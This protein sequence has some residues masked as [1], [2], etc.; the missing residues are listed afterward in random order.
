MDVKTKRPLFLIIDGSSLLT[1]AYFATLPLEIKICKTEAEREPLYRKLMHA[2]DGTFT[3][4][5]YGFC[6]TFTQMLRD[7]QPNMVAVVF[8]RTRD[9]F[10]R[11]MYPE[12]KAQ[13]KETARPLKEQ[14]I[15]I[16]DILSACGIVALASEEY[17]AD[18][19]AGTLTERYKNHC[20]I[21]LYTKDRDYLQLV[22]DACDVR[23]LM[24]TDAEKA[25]GFRE[26]YGGIYGADGIG[27]PQFWKTTVEYTENSVFG[28]FGIWP[29]NVIDLKAIEGDVSDNI[30]G[31]KG[32]SSAAV[33][34]INEYG[35]L[36]EIYKAIDGCD[37]VK[38]EKEL[39]AFWKDNLGIKRSPINAFVKYCGDAVLSKNLATIRTD[40][41]IPAETVQFFVK[42]T[43]RETFNSHMAALGIRTV[44]L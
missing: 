9:T 3:N 23:C 30:P 38:A 35:S 17:E 16:Q 21:R 26:R 37:G 22:D 6:M 34:L 32:V 4:A 5:V 15:L 29:K 40:A 12:Y 18:D 39:A 33:P 27:L 25:A 20:R 11:R 41:P 36:E 42:N 1:T 19:L 31:I 8:D 24:H 28:E 7:L 43:D 2:P 14:F 10:R 13:R 44:R